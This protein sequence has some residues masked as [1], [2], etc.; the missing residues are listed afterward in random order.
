M[1]TGKARR[2]GEPLG[3][4]VRRRFRIAWIR[5][6]CAEL[7]REV[8][9]FRAERDAAHWHEHDA[10]NKLAQRKATLAM[11][12]GTWSGPSVIMPAPRRAPRV[13]VMRAPEPPA[14]ESAPVGDVEVVGAVDRAGVVRMRPRAGRKSTR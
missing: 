13:V 14:A 3:D 2:P 7:A 4:F 11:L 8:E 5:R 1:T 12:L 9:R 6:R 10:A